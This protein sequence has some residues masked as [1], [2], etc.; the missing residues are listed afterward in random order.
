MRVPRRLHPLLLLLAGLIGPVAHAEFSLFKNAWGDVIVATDTTEA[1]KAIP[2]PSPDRPAYYLGMS[3][4]CKLGSMPGDEEPDPKQLELFVAGILAKQG[5]RG[6]QAGD[7]EPSLL[8]VLQ[9]GY[10]RPGSNDLAW[11]LGY[12]ASQ[13]IAAPSTV[14]RG[15]GPEVWRRSLRSRI[16]RTVLEYAAEPVYGIIV[17]AFDF[18]TARTPQP[19]LYWQTRIALPANGKSMAEA[20]PAMLRAAGPAI[21][22]S[23]DR[24]LLIDVD[25]PREGRVELGDLRVLE[26]DVRPPDARARP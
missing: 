1:G 20:L 9:W 24:P 15:V 6:A 14:G 16:T 2:A 13:D 3:L 17:T 21:G 12:D 19:V 7:H 25:R 4:G 22:R 5:Y 8:L 26:Q 23:A 10:L 11:F 18:R